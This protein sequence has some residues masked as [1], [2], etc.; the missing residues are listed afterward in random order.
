M[1]DNIDVLLT[2][3][4]ITDVLLDVNECQEKNRAMLIALLTCLVNKGI[5]NWRDIE[6][7]KHANF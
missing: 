3:N 1:G 2:I 7:I 6:A 4:K 5:L